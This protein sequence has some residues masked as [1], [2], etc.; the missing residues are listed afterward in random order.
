VLALAARGSA[1]L[2]L[3]TAL[4]LWPHEA[5]H[6]CQAGLTLGTTWE[7]L[8][9]IIPVA[10][11]FILAAALAAAILLCSLPPSASWRRSS[12]QHTPEEVSAR[13]GPS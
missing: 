7:M 8:V 13:C 12:G 10:L 1:T 11:P 2:A 3:L 5:V 4:V 6:A 9:V